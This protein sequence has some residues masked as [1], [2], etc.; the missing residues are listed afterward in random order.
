MFKIQT[1]KSLIFGLVILIV[2][3]SFLFITIK[4]SKNINDILDG[5]CKD[6]LWQDA[7]HQMLQE[8]LWRERDAY[9]A[10]HYLMIP[11]HAAFVSR[12][13]NKTDD[14]DKFFKRFIKNYKQDNFDSA[15]DLQKLHF[16]YLI[17][18]YLILN[19]EN[20]NEENFEKLT[21]LVL[22]EIKNI[23]DSPAWQ[24][25]VCGN[26]S[27]SN[28][29][30]RINWKLEN[31]EV[32]RSFCR[33]IIDEELFTF[34]IAADIQFILEEEA[35]KFISE[36]LDLAYKTFKSE[37]VFLDTKSG[38]WLLQPG[39]WT[40]HSDYAYSGNDEIKP[41]LKEN[42]I[43]GIAQDTSH[44]HR[45]PLW[46]VSLERSF[47][48]RGEQDKSDYFREL[49]YGLAKQF[50]EEVLVVPDDKFPNYRTKNFMDGYNGIYRYSYITQGKDRGYG[51]YE[52]SGTML[53][54]W[55]SF[56]PEEKIR[57]VYC[58]IS[59]HFPLNEE[60]IKVYLGPDTTRDRHPLIKG[61][62]QYESGLLELI[63]KF[64]CELIL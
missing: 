53:L 3:L 64:A 63:N 32:S 38:K 34:A 41:N 9:D 59:S 50:L 42:P 55:W 25:Q 62:A 5:S 2:F 37:I 56:L 31:K 39:A 4:F 36:I 51:P 52:L 20:K 16:L 26:S 60:E 11:M 14:F 28:M 45:F 58:H 19:K 24:W 8:P 6:F 12:D 10:G 57:S 33:A 43:P 22:E 35:P 44:S 23:W 48:T 29:D 21:N 46:L 17:S 27:F 15:D 54:G 7:I 30:L 1:R 18:E 49:R 61:R 13:E 40:D 47:N